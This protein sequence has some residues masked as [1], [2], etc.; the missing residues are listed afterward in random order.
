MLMSVS[1]HM[2]PGKGP[3]QGIISDR[4]RASVGCYHLHQVDSQICTAVMLPHKAQPSLNQPSQPFPE[5]VPE[6]R[7]QSLRNFPLLTWYL[8]AGA[9][10]CF[11]VALQQADSPLLWLVSA[12]HPSVT[13]LAVFCNS[14]MWCVFSTSLHRISLLLSLLFFFVCEAEGNL[15]GRMDYCSG[16]DSWRASVPVAQ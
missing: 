13:A 11:E 14:I 8:D 3:L 6:S 10:C 4:V 12:A 1:S 5:L 15:H 2:I 16:N 9:H 7:L